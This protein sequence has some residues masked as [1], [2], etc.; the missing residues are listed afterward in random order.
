MSELRLEKRRVERRIP[1]GHRARKG[2]D[3]KEKILGLVQDSLAGGSFGSRNLGR[4]IA[5]P[6]VF[7][8]GSPK[9]WRIVEKGRNAD[10]TCV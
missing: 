2:A 10:P 7:D 8:E 5:V 4:E 9:V 3:S 1:K 6:E